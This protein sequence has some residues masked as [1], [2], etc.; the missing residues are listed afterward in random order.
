MPSRRIAISI[1]VFGLAVLGV[2]RAVVVRADQT[3]D[4]IRRAVQLDPDPTAPR[5]VRLH[6]T[7]NRLGF[8]RPCNCSGITGEAADAEATFLRT[9]QGD[10][11]P[12]LRLDSGGFVHYD[13]TDL[14]RIRTAFLL[15]GLSL[16]HLDAINVTA[17]DLDI[18]V[19][20]LLE[21]ARRYRLPLI[22]ANLHR[23]GESELLF[24]PSRILEARDPAG[25]VVAKI[26][27]IGVSPAVTPVYPTGTI[28]RFGLPGYPKPP[29]T[30]PVPADRAGGS[31]V[32][33]RREIRA[34][35]PRKALEEEVAR[36]RPECDC[37]IVLT[38]LA[39]SGAR[40][41]V[42]GVPGIDVVVAGGE[43]TL[44]TEAGILGTTPV[45]APGAQGTGVA[46]L[47]VSFDAMGAVAGMAGTT[48]DLSKGWKP[49]PDIAAL[50]HAQLKVESLSAGNGAEGESAEQSE[51]NSAREP[52][53]FV[54]A[55]TC[56]DCHFAVYE[57]W[58]S[59]RHGVASFETLSSRH[60]A[61][62]PLCFSCHT[63]GSGHAGGFDSVESTPGLKGIQ[64]ESCHG[65]S[66]RHVAWA[67]RE[68]RTGAA[69]ALVPPPADPRAQ[70]AACHT[71][72]SDPGYLE[73][74]LRRRLA[75]PGTVHSLGR[76]DR[77]RKSDTGR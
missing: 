34:S 5:R 43:T 65:P 58:A 27:V 55:L 61:R 60:S 70:C 68:W 66:D 25:R 69:A 51:G 59:S 75:T 76:P 57:E 4:A 45:I 11:T 21:A 14:T 73:P 38:R 2:G 24:P 30:A 9:F 15:Q 19:D 33:I 36:I 31:N 6:F 22:S 41:L 16:L 56:R 20:T 8:L 64:C 62:D 50:I 12:L 10:P 71:P 72:H 46:E 1:A 77:L 32:Q 37:L 47:L 7:G 18:G 3:R 40:G 42:D 17:D 39:V 23:A 74:A 53:T 35:S 52:G 49:D 67:Y 26:G 29:A 48:H 63:T 13:T 28:P 44:N 54:G